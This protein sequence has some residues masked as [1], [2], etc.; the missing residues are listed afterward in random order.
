[1]G[2]DRKPTKQEEQAAAAA[3]DALNNGDMA[4]A[5]LFNKLLEM[6]IEDN[7]KAEGK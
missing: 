7:D 2:I 5:K 6:T 1:M 3:L 4:K